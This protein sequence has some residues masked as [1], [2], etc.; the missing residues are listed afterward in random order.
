MSW[1][2]VNKQRNMVRRIT[3][4]LILL[5]ASLLIGWDIVAAVSPEQ[6][7]TISEL[8]QKTGTNWLA[9][10]FAFGALMGHFFLPRRKM[11]TFVQYWLGFGALTGITLGL[12]VFKAFA[13]KLFFN[14]T[15]VALLVGVPVG[16]ALW[17][18]RTSY[19]DK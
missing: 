8:I 2:H 13:S 5:S 19:N 18:Q 4:G 15:L 6:G 7:D 11:P 14:H 12:F 3:I 16:S 9:L 1:Q 17:P 10:P